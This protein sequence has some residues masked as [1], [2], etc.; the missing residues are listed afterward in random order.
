[1][2][3]QVIIG[4]LSLSS[5]T[6][7]IGLCALPGLAWCVWRAGISWSSRLRAVDALLL[8]GACALA[9]GRAGYIALNAAYFAERPAEI[10]LAPAAGISEHAAIVGMLIGWRLARRFN[11]PDPM[12]VAALASLIGIG[13]SIGCVSNACAYGREVFWTDG[14]LWHLRVDWPDA[15]WM[16][17]PRLPA[18]ACMAAWLIV[19]MAG[20]A[21]ASRRKGGTLRALAVWLLLFGAG[22][23][24]LQFG[25][26]DTTP[27]LLGLRVHQSLDVGLLLLALGLGA[28]DRPLRPANHPQG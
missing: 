11:R 5:Y 12:R 2:S 1:M 25:R 17:N 13:A 14:L 10:T 8:L 24:I 28:A 22:D 6:F 16:S 4:P 15:H 21:V 18:Q 19:C 7:W 9:A 20:A 26:A 27:M 23:F 3:T